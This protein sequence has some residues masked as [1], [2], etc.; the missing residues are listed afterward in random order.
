M[1]KAAAIG[2]YDSIYG[3][4]AAGIDIFAVNTEE[5]CI[6]SFKK[7]VSGGYGVVFI[8]ERFA[9]N[10]FVRAHMTSPVPAVLVIPD[11]SGSTGYAMRELHGMVE[12]AAGADLL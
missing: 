5:E 8:T 3:L 6:K 12:K 11:A 1:Y 2:Y 9:D 4:E 7:A 10:S